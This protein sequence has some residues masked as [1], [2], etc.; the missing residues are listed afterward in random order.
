MAISI[1]SRHNENV[2]V[3]HEAGSDGLPGRQPGS[4]EQSKATASFMALSVEFDRMTMS[5]RQVG[6]SQV[7]THPPTPNADSWSTVT[8]PR[9]SSLPTSRFDACVSNSDSPEADPPSRTGRVVQIAL[10]R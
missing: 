9:F 3:H 5:L 4:S 8:H 7:S 6:E 10:C 1:G 2:V